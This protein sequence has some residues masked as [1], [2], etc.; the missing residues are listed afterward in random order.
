MINNESAQI[1]PIEVLFTVMISIVIMAFLLLTVGPF[2]DEFVNLI[3]TLDI[4][5]SSWGQGMMTNL[6][7]KYA[8]YVFLVPTFF[9][10]V[11]M[12]WG[13]KT[14]IKRHEYTTQQQ[15]QFMNDEI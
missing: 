14:V 13:L 7:I 10:I 11:M 3:N 4:P 5:L 6:P 1:N 2:V 12:V 8:S 15:D 9:I